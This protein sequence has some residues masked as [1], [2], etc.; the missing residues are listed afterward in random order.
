MPRIAVLLLPVQSEGA[1]VEGPDGGDGG[2]S[3]KMP[4]LAVPQELNNVVTSVIVP[5]P[6]AATDPEKVMEGPLR[7]GL[8]TTF[9][10][11]DGSQMDVR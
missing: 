6:D 2:S 9:E 10:L 1:I 4:G 8:R 11:S 7:A 5:A 3:S